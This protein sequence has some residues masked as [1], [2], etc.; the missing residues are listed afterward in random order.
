MND[1][2]DQKDL[3]AERDWMMERWHEYGR[4]FGVF[5]P[6]QQPAPEV[7]EPDLPPPDEKGRLD[8]QVLKHWEQLFPTKNFLRER[9]A[10]YKILQGSTLDFDCLVPK[11]QRKMTHRWDTDQ[12]GNPDPQPVQDS[13]EWY[14][15]ALRIG[16]FK[17]EVGFSCRSRRCERHWCKLSLKNPRKF[18]H[19]D[20][21]GLIQLFEVCGAAT[22]LSE[23]AK[24]FNVKLRPFESKGSHKD[25]ILRYAVPKSA[26]YGLIDEYR[27]MRHQHV[28]DFISQAKSIIQS[29]AVLEWHRRMF[30][31]E[32]CFLSMKVTGNLHKINSPSA[33]AYLW[34][35]V[36][37]EELARRTKVSTEAER[38]K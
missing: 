28:S 14:D 18:H 19:V 20:L 35:L 5:V 1:I 23:V 24:G 37:Q 16:I 36:R 22:A 11:F 10:Q 33:K 3:D 15:S 4:E 21:Y 7:W 34:L 12:F 38:R 29:S 8:P 31:E 30:D 27:T 32:Y 9:Y 25:R 26:I 6:E 13:H 2:N 17:W